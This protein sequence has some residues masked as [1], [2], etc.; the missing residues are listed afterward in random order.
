MRGV[1]KLVAALPLGFE[2]DILLREACKSHIHEM[3][4]SVKEEWLLSRPSTFHLARS[5]FML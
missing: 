4:S 1:R 2:L 5:S 3:S